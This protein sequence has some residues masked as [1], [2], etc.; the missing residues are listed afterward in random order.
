M[1]VPMRN[2]LIILN[3]IFIYLIRPSNPSSSVARFPV[4]EPA[5][6]H[7]HVKGTVRL[8]AQSAE[9]SSAIEVSLIDY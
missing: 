5:L 2:A 7:E 1:S 4:D 8:R 9:D 3:I 6:A